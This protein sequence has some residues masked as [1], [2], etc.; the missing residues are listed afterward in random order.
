MSPH[1]GYA[2]VHA[3]LRKCM[4]CLWVLL[5][6]ETNSSTVVYMSMCLALKSQHMSH[7][8]APHIVDALVRVNNA[9]CSPTASSRLAVC[10]HTFT[11]FAICKHTFL[12][13][14]FTV[15][16]HTVYNT[17]TAL[18]MITSVYSH[19]SELTSVQVYIPQPYMYQCVLY[20][21]QVSVHRR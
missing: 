2:P 13:C 14:N 1:S 16:L 12:V 20:T 5:Q 8:R 18:H 9:V 11:A 7:I 10:S 3:V 15:A 21:C 4:T 19:M 17:T 6:A